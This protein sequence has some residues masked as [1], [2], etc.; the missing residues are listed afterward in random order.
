MPVLVE[1]SEAQLLG[2]PGRAP[3]RAGSLGFPLAAAIPA[4]L[5]RCCF[6]SSESGAGDWRLVSPAAPRSRNQTNRKTQ[7]EKSGKLKGYPPK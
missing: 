6:P 3:E 1:Q 5:C 7:P 2:A 4:G